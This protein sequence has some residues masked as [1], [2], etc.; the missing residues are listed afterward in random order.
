MNN[1]DNIIDSRDVIEAFENLNDEAESLFQALTD[2]YEDWET[3]HD[4]D[5]LEAV[6][7]AVVALQDWSDYDDWKELKAL[8]EEAEDCGDWNHGAT[9]ILDSYFEQYA[10]DLADDIGATR[11]QGWPNDYI[12]WEAAA[13]ALKM[14][15]TSVNFGDNEYWIRS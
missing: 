13:N 12:D 3:E 11:E 7:D 4:Y 8:I 1:G 10:R 2:S 14:D 9:L 6:K 5:K 15:Y